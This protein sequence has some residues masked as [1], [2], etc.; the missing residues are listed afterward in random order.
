MPLT[1][2]YVVYIYKAACV[3]VSFTLMEK[4]EAYESGSCIIFGAYTMIQFLFLQLQWHNY[5]TEISV[6]DSCFLNK[7]CNSTISQCQNLTYACN[8]LNFS[9][10]RPLILHKLRSQ[11]FSKQVYC[12]PCM[13]VQSMHMLNQLLGMCRIV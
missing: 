2:V 4:H 7:A 3:A 9:Y 1:Y 13:Y 5:Y 6:L 11:L 12:L 8:D 10:H